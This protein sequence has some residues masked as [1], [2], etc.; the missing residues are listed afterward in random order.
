MGYFTIGLLLGILVMTCICESAHH[1]EV[2]DLK[3]KINQD[4]QYHYDV[5]QQLENEL[6]TKRKELESLK[7]TINKLHTENNK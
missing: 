2:S 1:D 7:E 4:R 3:K 6:N 5:V